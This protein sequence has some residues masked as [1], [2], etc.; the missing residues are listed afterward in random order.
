MRE[1]LGPVVERLDEKMMPESQLAPQAYV[2]VYPE[3]FA[4]LRAAGW[5]GECFPTYPQPSWTDE[6]DQFMPHPTALDFI[7]QFEGLSISEPGRYSSG[8]LAEYTNHIKF[9]P[10][11][12]FAHMKTTC[13]DYYLDVRDILEDPDPFP[14]A[15][16]NGQILFLTQSGRTAFIDQTLCGYN[17]APNPF[18]LFN[19]YLFSVND[20]RID[21]KAGYF[22]QRITGRPWW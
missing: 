11:S 8:K 12:A 20:D 13:D 18:V 15:E 19:T 7:V 3:L 22:G 10:G 14:V 5:T 9:Y 17:R 16:S 2:D 4:K 6:A 1:L 21:G